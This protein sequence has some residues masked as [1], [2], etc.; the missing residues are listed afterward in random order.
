MEK[1]KLEP[2]MELY[3][4]ITP[5]YIGAA[6]IKVLK[7]IPYEK[8][9]TFA[10]DYASEV[11]IL[12]EKASYAYRSP[13]FQ[14]YEQ[15]YIM[16]YYTN[17]DVSEMDSDS[18]ADLVAPFWN[19][20]YSAIQGDYAITEALANNFVFDTINLYNY[21]HGLQK[22]I[23]ESFGS[24]LEG[25]DVVKEVA[26]SREINEKMIDMLSNANDVSNKQTNITAFSEFAKRD[27]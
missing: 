4:E 21:T 2:N 18:V 12:D 24:I 16:E 10:T 27:L 20:I 26:Q 13:E 6:E 7:R 22:K 5:V 11:C 3:D 8:K 25:G 23:L 17:L 15:Y 14:K 9:I 1:I 19:D